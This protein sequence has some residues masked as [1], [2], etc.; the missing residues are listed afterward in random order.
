VGSGAEVLPIYGKLSSGEQERVVN[1][2]HNH[3]GNVASCRLIA[4]GTNVCQAGVTID[5]LKFVV[6]CGLEKQ[7]GYDSEK[8]EGTLGVEWISQADAQQRKGRAGRTAPGVCYRLYPEA[9]FVGMAR[10]NPPEITRESCEAVVL[11]LAS[12]GCSAKTFDFLTPPNGAALDQAY[13]SLQNLGALSGETLTCVGEQMCHLSQFLSSRTARFAIHCNDRGCGMEGLTI[14]YVMDSFTASGIGK[15][16]RP[17]RKD[18]TDAEKA[19]YEQE[20]RNITKGCTSDHIS[21]YLLF[22]NGST[23]TIDMGAKQSARTCIRDATDKLNGRGYPVTSGGADLHEVVP[24]GLALAFFHK[25][26]RLNSR[27]DAYDGTTFL[28]SLNNQKKQAIINRDSVLMKKEKVGS[29]AEWRNAVTSSLVVFHK[30]Q[31]GEDGKFRMQVL[32]PV[33]AKL[34]PNFEPGVD[35]WMP[36]PRDSHTCQLMLGPKEKDVRTS[37][38]GAYPNL[39]RLAEQFASKPWVVLK[40]TNSC[41]PKSAKAEPDRRGLYVCAPRSM[42]NTVKATV[43]A[44]LKAIEPV[45]FKLS[46]FPAAVLGAFNGPQARNVKLLQTRL[47]TRFKIPEGGLRLASSKRQQAAGQGAPAAA[48][49]S[50]WVQRQDPASG[51]RYYYHQFT[52]VS[53]WEEP[54]E[55]AAE[56]SQRPIVSI[57]VSGT[58][59]HNHVQICKGV[60]D[61]LRGHCPL[62][63]FLSFSV[64]TSDPWQLG[65]QVRQTDFRKPPACTGDVW[66]KIVTSPEYLAKLVEKQTAS[67]GPLTSVPRMSKDQIGVWVSFS[68]K[69]DKHVHTILQ[70]V[71]RALIPAMIVEFDGIHADVMRGLIGHGGSNIKRVAE[72]FR[73]FGGMK[74][75]GNVL[76]AILYNA[77]D[78]RRAVNFLRMELAKWSSLKF[79][80]YGVDKIWQIIGKGGCTIK[81]LQASVRACCQPF[82]AQVVVDTN[83]GEVVLKGVA[84]GGSLEDVAFGLV[85]EACERACESGYVKWGKGGTGSDGQIPKLSTRVMHINTTMI[86]APPDVQV[87]NIKPEV[88]A[89]L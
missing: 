34:L 3:N 70:E 61:E 69:D 85:K 24:S 58:V 75:S 14:G 21:L 55:A 54:P 64:E 89:S 46:G 77:Q 51:R 8:Q 33:D 11:K 50:A 4:F 29:S 26:A 28:T 74:A 63:Y 65:L 78:E 57:I 62:V 53:C 47:C 36:L 23:T 82:F 80:F 12:V 27:I 71:H 72:D 73:I 20:T 66:V 35:V 44:Y 13:E 16:L 59:K 5:G 48:A 18:W 19:A 56:K 7:A 38:L 83:S 60:S 49:T 22:E 37:S 42:I 1:F 40:I 79:T 81:A 45:V 17:F 15:V 68:G 86:Q 52:G 67:S 87:K 32:T 39:K 41:R 31:D 6:D 9:T 88:T 43:A 10:Y 76:L 25:I 2:K 84:G 30:V